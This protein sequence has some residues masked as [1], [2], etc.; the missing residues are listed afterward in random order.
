[1]RFGTWPSA[2]W[3][4]LHLL[5]NKNKNLNHEKLKIMEGF[6]NEPFSCTEGHYN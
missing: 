1:V 2:S 6:K 3:K 5:K 4:I